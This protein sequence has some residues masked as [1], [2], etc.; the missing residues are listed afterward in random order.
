MNI[1]DVLNQSTKEVQSF[2]VA[3]EKEKIF[4]KLE[5]AR[6]KTGRPQKKFEEKAKKRSIY[7]TDR[8]YEKIEELAII[9][10]MTTTN[11]IKFCVNKELKKEE[12]SNQ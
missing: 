8:E 2:K 12:K 9:Y 3:S 11:F 7:Y 6:K 4:K 5:T 10:G 1:D